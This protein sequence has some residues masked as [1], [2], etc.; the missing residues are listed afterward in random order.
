LRRAERL[1]TS[2]II[3]VNIIPKRMLTKAEAS[4]HCGRSI[5]RFEIECPIS[6]IAFPNGDRRY[7]VHDLD[8]WLD[9]VKHG[10]VYDD[11]DQIITRLG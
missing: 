10:T 4:V 6:P 7:D 9:D 1:M 8:A 5:K 3:Q 11:A 2:A